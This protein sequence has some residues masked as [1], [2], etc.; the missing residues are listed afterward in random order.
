[1]MSISQCFFVPQ[2]VCTTVDE[3][4][5]GVLLNTRIACSLTSI[6]HSPLDES[7][8]QFCAAS[9]VLALEG[10]HKVG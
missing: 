4:Y 1:M 6:I 7:S 8:A 10:L 5:A 2:I 3:L 9:V